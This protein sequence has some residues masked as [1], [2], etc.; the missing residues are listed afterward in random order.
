MYNE[1]LRLRCQ[2]KTRR[3]SRNLVNGQD[4]QILDDFALTVAL[5][6]IGVIGLGGS[7]K[8]FYLLLA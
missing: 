3:K 4:T 7:D 8:S 1:L 5:Y 6:E 2:R